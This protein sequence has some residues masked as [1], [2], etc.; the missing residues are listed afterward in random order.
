MPLKKADGQWPPPRLFC[1]AELGNEPLRRCAPAP[2]GKGSLCFELLWW[3]QE[4]GAP[5]LPRIPK[6]E[7]N[8]VGPIWKGRMSQRI[9]SFRGSYG[10][11]GNGMKFAHS[12]VKQ[13]EEGPNTFPPQ[14]SLVL[15][16]IDD[17]TALVLT[18]NL[19][20]AVRHAESAAVGALYYAGSGELPHGRPSLV[21]SLSGYFSFWDCHVD[22]S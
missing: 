22:T 6:S 20:G 15:L 18:A 11:R 2:L 9:C 19:A 13:K 8:E 1:E 3:E 16:N 10:N 7:P 4:S 21:T 5:T 17:C 14:A 12:D